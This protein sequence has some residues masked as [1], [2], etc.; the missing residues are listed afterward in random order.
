MI[1]FFSMEVAESFA[2]KLGRTELDP[3]TI[4]K[5][6]YGEESEAST[7]NS[8]EVKWRRA[9]KRREMGENE[10]LESGRKKYDR[11]ELRWQWRSCLS[12]TR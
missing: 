4:G 7:T 9:C 12:A 1:M 3:S 2:D 6:E 11:R 10:W 5:L 8:L